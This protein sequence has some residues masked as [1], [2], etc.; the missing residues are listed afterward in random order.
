MQ[1]DILLRGLNLLAPGGRLV[2]STCSLNPIENEAVVAGALS[3]YNSIHATGVKSE[4]EESS[5]SE[6]L[7]E[8]IDTRDHPE[9]ARFRSLKRRPGMTEWRVT[10]LK[11]L[12]TLRKAR[13]KNQEDMAK[14]AAA[15]AA[16]AVGGEQS[17]AATNDTVKEEESAATIQKTEP[18]V[19]ATGEP[20]EA[21]TAAA[22]LP[23]VDSW[24]SL[25]S[26]F[27]DE[28]RKVAKTFW[29]PPSGPERDALH[30][31]RCMRIYP[32]DQNS[33]GFFVAVLEK[34]QTSAN[35]KNREVGNMAPGI[36][37]GIEA[38]DRQKKDESAATTSQV[39]AKREREEEQEENIAPAGKKGKGPSGKAVS[40]NQADEGL[41]SSFR[42]HPYSYLANDNECVLAFKEYYSLS[43]DFCRNLMVRNNTGDAMRMVYYTAPVVRGIL[44]GGGEATNPDAV[45]K[46][47]QTARMRLIYTGNKLFARQGAL[48]TQTAGEDD[49]DSAE[50]EDVT[51]ASIKTKQRTLAQTWRI[52]D[53]GKEIL[54][55]V[56]PANRKFSMSIR[57]LQSLLMENCPRLDDV[58]PAELRTRLAALA[59]GSHIVEILAGTDEA[60]GARLDDTILLSIWKAPASVGIMLDK[61]ERSAVSFR[62]YGKDIITGSSQ[63]TF[64]QQKHGRNKEQTPAA[65]A[66]KTE[67]ADGGAAEGAEADVSAPAID[68][69]DDAALNG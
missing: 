10:P 35:G 2:Y 45:H 61:Q 11:N 21:S 32:H 42:E 8:L 23:W 62:I 63:R 66:Y 69:D 56:L 14:A 64:T 12:G 43:D 15:A 51:A 27:P 48:T 46:L 28:S 49:D 3:E 54:H 9:F 41:D 26:E 7:V 22:D 59:S 34:K 29:P 19:G 52:T 65:S 4:G 44:T 38:L 47:R 1:R 50:A 40:V 18:K 6:P 5:S 67:P 55:K 20:E 17:T 37:R 39:G 58:E 25:H 13:R 36:Q 16:T 68:I 60:L 30:L 33:G 24:D 31:E 57:D 53:D